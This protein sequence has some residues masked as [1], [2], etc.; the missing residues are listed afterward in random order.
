MAHRRR[1]TAG[2][3][4]SY[5]GGEVRRI[6]H[7]LNSYRS[8]SITADG[9]ALATVQSQDAFS[10]YVVDLGNELPEDRIALT[11]VQKLH[12]SFVGP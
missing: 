4:I 3:S 9:G 7:D 10:L 6:T 11:P 12:A 1:V 8:V 2:L 5:P